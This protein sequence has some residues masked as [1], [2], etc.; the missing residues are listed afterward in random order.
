MS[1]L[2][3]YICVLLVGLAIVDLN[4]IL[5]L[6]LKARQLIHECEKLMFRLKLE[7]E[8]REIMS[9]KKRYQ[10]MAEDILKDLQSKDNADDN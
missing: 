5:Y 6:S 2:S 3:L 10:K 4:I 1:H 8:I 7:W 9:N